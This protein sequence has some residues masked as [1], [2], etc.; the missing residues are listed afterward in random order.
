MNYYDCT[1][2]IS[3]PTI[4]TLNAII[5]SPYLTEASFVEYSHKEGQCYRFDGYWPPVLNSNQT[6]FMLHTYSR[7]LYDL[8]F[9]D[10][11]LQQYPEI[12]IDIL[13]FSM[14]ARW[15]HY[16]LSA[17]KIYLVFDKEDFVNDVLNNRPLY[18]NSGIFELSDY[19]FAYDFM[20]P[21]H[22]TWTQLLLDRDE[23]GHEYRDEDKNKKYGE[24]IPFPDELVPNRFKE[25]WHQ[26]PE[27]FKK[28]VTTLIEIWQRLEAKEAKYK[29]PKTPLDDLDDD[30]PF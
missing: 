24:I 5:E 9:F 1:I 4:E 14:R 22:R 19:K 25:V 10:D 6:S 23:D 13:V 26:E 29:P 27:T 15:A 12:T 28:E 7:G 30:M 2:Q 21:E 11:I 16:R 3:A 18:Y 20:F 8:S 17:K